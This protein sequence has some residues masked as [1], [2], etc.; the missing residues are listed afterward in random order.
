VFKTNVKTFVSLR[1]VQPPLPL[2]DLQRIAEFFPQPGFEF[3]LD[4]AY[5]HEHESAD[6]EKTVVFAI[7]QKYNR[8]NL[9]VPVGTTHPYHAALESKTMKLTATGEHYRRIVAAGL[10]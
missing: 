9:A 8:V 3:Q 7:L 1:Q 5:E 2:G 10:I 6:P 4:P